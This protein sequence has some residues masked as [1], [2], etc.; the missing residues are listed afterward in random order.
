M[1]V[2][3]ISSMQAL[4][5]YDDAPNLVNNHKLALLEYLDRRQYKSYKIYSVS[6]IVAVCLIRVAGILF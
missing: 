5:L 4:G 6:F 2:L 1:N 3:Y